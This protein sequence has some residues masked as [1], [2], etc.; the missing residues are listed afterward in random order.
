[1]NVTH[2]FRR[3]FQQSCAIGYQHINQQFK[4]FGVSRRTMSKKSVY[5]TRTINKEALDIL[6][7]RF[8][9][10]SWTGPGPVPRD[11]LLKNIKNKSGLFC[12]LTDKIDAEVLDTAGK[13]LKIIATM[14]VGYD[15]FDVNEI[16]KRDI[17][18][19][20]TPDILTDATAELAVALLLATSRR[21]LEANQEAKTGG[22][23]AWSPFWMC[24]PGLKDST[25][26]IVGFGRIGQEIAKRLKPFGTKR[27][28]YFNRSE[29]NVEATKI[30]AERVTFDELLTHS[31]FVSVSCALTPE[32]KNLFDEKAFGKMKK[33]AVF[34][35]TSRG[36][37]VDQDALVEA[38][39]NGT[40]WGAGLDVTTPEPLPL[41]HPLFGLKNCV[42]LPHIGSACVQTRNDMAV[43]TAKNIAAA[44]NGEPLLTELIV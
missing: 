29:K 5:I 17:K 8:D 42:I 18:M 30:G 41:E 34:V 44:L 36:G 25:V 15:H 19:A 37:V 22:W 9:V 1:M 3:I 39:R 23:K 2:Y 27:I 14:S 11:E 24:G 12:M 35:N 38:L 28:L 31:D 13:N 26:G 10:A 7:E 43:L 4:I 6:T 33:T 32:T 21:L 40:I 16:K 20:Y